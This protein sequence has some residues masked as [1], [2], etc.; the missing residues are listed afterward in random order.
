[1]IDDSL[2]DIKSDPPSGNN[3][4]ASRGFILGSFKKFQNFPIRNDDRLY[5]NE[6]VLVV[7]LRLN[8]LV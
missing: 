6:A 5:L 2:C 4:A 1:M 3:N 8:E 7:I